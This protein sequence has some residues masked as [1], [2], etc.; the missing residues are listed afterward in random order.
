MILLYWAKSGKWQPMQCV[1]S[2]ASQVCTIT[3]RHLFDLGYSRDDIRKPVNNLQTF[4]G[5]AEAI[6]KIDLVLEYEN[7]RIEV[8]FDVFDKGTTTL[9]TPLLGVQEMC[10]LNLMDSRK[11]GW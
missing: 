9:S 7:K 6:G 11:W 2:T 4:L 8:N 1:L 3:F 5:P 10:E